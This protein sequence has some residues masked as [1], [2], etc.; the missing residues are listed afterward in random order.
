MNSKKF[1]FTY[2]ILTLVLVT[3]MAGINY[4]IDIYGLFRGKKDR[5]VYINERT[6]KYLMSYRYIP[7]NFEGF[8][9]GPSLSANLNPEQIKEY[10]I[11]N[12][13]IMG[14]NISELNYLVD[15]IVERGNMKFAIICLDP[16]LTKDHGRKSANITTEEYYGALGSTNLLKTYLL[17]FVRNNNIAP[18]RYAPDLHNTVGWNNFE[19][20]TH[21]IDSKRSIEEKAAKR[22]YEKT[23]IDPVAYKELNTTLIKLR[24]KNIKII[25]YFSPVPYKLYQLGKSDYHKFEND[26]SALFT[27]NDVLINLNEDQYKDITNDYNTFIDHGHLSANGQRFVLSVLERELKQLF[28]PKVNYASN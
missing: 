21:N 28:R 16:Y 19:K 22:Q 7:E 1:L 14:A 17:Y 11:Y 13:S 23:E 5:K 25:G 3:L 15:N 10:R 2:V 26:I 24:H 20:E 12:A 27:K 9:M 18:H 8:I 6:S 4:F